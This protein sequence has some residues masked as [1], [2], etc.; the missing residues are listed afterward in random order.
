MLGR[1]LPTTAAQD[2]VQPGIGWPVMGHLRLGSWD[3]DVRIGTAR[4][5]MTRNGTASDGT[6]KIGKLGMG[7]QGWDF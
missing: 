1:D 6:S 5:G 4:N 3:W 2:L 7:R